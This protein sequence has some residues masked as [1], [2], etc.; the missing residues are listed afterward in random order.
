MTIRQDI[1]ENLLT[2]QEGYSQLP[3]KVISELEQFQNNKLGVIFHWGLY[4]VAGIVESWQLS[5]EDNWARKQPWREDLAVL[6]KDYWALSQ[7][8]NP[9]SFNPTEW[10]LLCRNAGFRYMI[11]TTKHH[12]GFSMYDTQYS[13]YKVTS[14][15]CPFHT[16]K[17][18][19]IFGET[20]EA[21]R[22]AGLSVG[23]Y[24]SKADWASPYYWEPNS[25]PKGR[26]A[27]Y[28][29]EK[30]PK[31]WQKYKEFVSNQLH[32]LCTN[33]GKIDI[34]WLDGG[35]VNTENHEFLDMQ[36]IA[37]DVRE[38]QPQLLI[39]DR[40][41][42]GMY[43]NYVTPER[44][45]PEQLP[46]KVW[47]SN[48]PLAKNWGYVPNDTYKSFEE[49]LTLLLQIVSK[50]GNLLLGVGPK[51]DGTLPHK[52]QELMGQLGKWLAVYGTGIY[53]TRKHH[54]DQLD[55]WYFTAKKKQIY[56]FHI[57]QEQESLKLDL[58]KLQLPGKVAEVNNLKSGKS[59][60]INNNILIVPAVDQ[61]EAVTGI[62]ITIEI[63]GL[64]Q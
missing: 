55:G 32:E 22:N 54:V 38:Q 63:E 4:A 30:K 43:E 62:E 9:R 60:S 57:N 33:Y 15:I 11:F 28:D 1:E 64:T 16:S 2:E 37:V 47:E 20:A 59:Y 14:E 41:I 36:Q 27:S 8:F 29:P 23:V 39:V 13:N 19:D 58:A 7:T 17:R 40:T 42:G 44:K 56:G 18:K 31:V 53:G 49:I 10:A 51:P 21:F 24:Y 25:R 46:K 34:L 12:D 45:V 50:G 61:Q 5:E 6:R 3:E 26:Y 52:A 48:I 35:W